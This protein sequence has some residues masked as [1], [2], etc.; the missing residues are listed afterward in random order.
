MHEEA[1]EEQRKL[2]LWYGLREGEF[3]KFGNL[4]LST[5][6]SMPLILGKHGDFKFFVF[7][8]DL[9]STLQLLK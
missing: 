5:C 9:I 1:F 7:I 3:E 4:D 6:T 8:S 2:S